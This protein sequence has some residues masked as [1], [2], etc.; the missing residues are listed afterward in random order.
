MVIGDSKILQKCLFSQLTAL[1]LTSFVSKSYQ[2]MC[3]TDQMN[4]APG[5]LAEIVTLVHT[6]AQSA[7]LRLPEMLLHQL[8]A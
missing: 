6:S 2:A 8:D 1:V 5:C 7:S 4:V 3:V